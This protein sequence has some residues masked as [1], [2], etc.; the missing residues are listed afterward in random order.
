MVL[1]GIESPN[2]RRNFHTEYDAI[3]LTEVIEYALSLVPPVGKETFNGLPH[4][5]AY[6]LLRAAQLA[7]MGHLQVATRCVMLGLYDW[8]NLF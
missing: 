1:L 2:I 8:D 6:K 4:L 5:Q 7:E 3:R